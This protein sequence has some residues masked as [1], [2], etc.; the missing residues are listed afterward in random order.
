MQMEQNYGAPSSYVACTHVLVVMIEV[1]EHKET[2]VVYVDWKLMVQVKHHEVAMV[3]W[4]LMVQLEHHKL[5][6]VV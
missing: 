5:V 2:P 3:V 4:K 1:F 6:I